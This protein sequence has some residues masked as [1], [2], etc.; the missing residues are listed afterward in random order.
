MEVTSPFTGWN[1]DYETLVLSE[2]VEKAL[3]KYN[4]MR[5]KENLKLIKGL[6]LKLV[7]SD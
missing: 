4:E 2:E 3:N 1:L 5:K 7:G 6:V